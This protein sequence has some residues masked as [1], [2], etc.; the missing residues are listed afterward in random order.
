M[1]NGIERPNKKITKS[2]AQL[3]KRK[4][5]EYFFRLWLPYLEIDLFVFFDLFLFGSCTQ[6]F[7]C[8]ISKTVVNVVIVAINLFLTKFYTNFLRKFKQ[9][10]DIFKFVWGYNNYPKMNGWL[11]FQFCYWKCSKNYFDHTAMPLDTICSGNCHA[12]M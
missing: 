9:I 2:K 7:Y 12:F 8:F 6:K 10:I 3:Q 5:T 4:V 1:S 11:C